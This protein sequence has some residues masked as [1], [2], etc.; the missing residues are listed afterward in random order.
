MATPASAS[1]QPRKLALYVLPDKSPQPGTGHPALSIRRTVKNGK[2]R[3]VTAEQI[4]LF[5]LD[6]GRG[7]FLPSRDD[8]AREIGRVIL[9][10]AGV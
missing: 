7:I 6:W 5:G 9:D 3:Y 2:G 8:L 4:A 10:E 1:S